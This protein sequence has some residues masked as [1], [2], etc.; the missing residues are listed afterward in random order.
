MRWSS[1]MPA[2]SSM[3][4]VCTPDAMRPKRRRT[5]KATSSAAASSSGITSE[6]S[7]TLI[8]SFSPSGPAARSE[9]TWRERPRRVTSV[10]GGNSCTAAA[11]STGAG[12]AVGATSGARSPP[13][14][15]APPR[16]VAYELVTHVEHRDAGGGRARRRGP[17]PPR[18]SMT[19]GATSCSDEAPP[20]RADGTS[21]AR[22]VVPSHTVSSRTS[23]RAVKHPMRPMPEH[24]AAGC[25]RLVPWS[26]SPGSAA[27]SSGPRMPDALSRWYA[28]HL[29][30]GL[31]PESLEDDEAPTRSG[32]RRP[33]RP[34]SRP[35]GP[36]TGRART[37]ASTA[38]ASTSGCATST[39]WWRSC[40][41]WNR[42][43]R[44]PRDAPQRPLRPAAR[45]RGERGA[46]VG[47]G[48]S[49]SRAQLRAELLS[50]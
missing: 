42:G 26:A 41:T 45:P 13:V 49:R 37:W 24:G 36:S 7:G 44:R 14:Q 35:S 48:L 50:R 40:A 6:R 43:R 27:S 21:V 32:T 5:E 12:G 3:A 38:G 8:L 18:G 46:V 30:I 16:H 2:P 47:A 11:G 23:I 4:I 31:P 39:R 33:G 25:G 15:P 10:P 19:I 22:G 20:P 9:S 34:S 28:E 29:G 1:N 17:S